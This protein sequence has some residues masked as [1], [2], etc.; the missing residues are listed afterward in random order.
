MFTLFVGSIAAFN[1]IMMF[2]MAL[3][4][5][6]L[7][8]VVL[9]N[10]LYWWVRARR[11]KG[12]LIGVRQAGGSF[13]SVFRYSLEGQS[14]EATSDQGSTTLQGRETGA[15]VPLLIIPGNFTVAEEAR[16]HVWTLVGALS[17]ALGAWLFHVA[18]RLYPVGPMTWVAGG[19][20]ALYFGVKIYR[21]AQKERNAPA[22][23]TPR[24]AVQPVQCIEDLKAQPERRA[25]AERNQALQRRWAPVLLVVGVTLLGLS[26]YLGHNLVHLETTGLR[27]PGIV[28]SLERSAP[29]SHGS[30]YH[31]VVSFVT[32]GGDAIRFRD[33]TGSNPPAYRVGD[34]VTVLYLENDSESTTIDRGIWNWLIPALVLLFG[35]LLCI[36]SVPALARK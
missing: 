22:R 31:P 20:L 24:A 35:G 21:L 3:F 14:Y 29:D 5:A 28:Q 7:G 33:A 9:G 18:V 34:H 13:H 12:E 17:A 19:L 26:Y 11:I 23:P 8:G 4:F 15:I 30:T 25:E 36:I 32:R 1:Q 6:A 2:A 10:A 27:A 16:S